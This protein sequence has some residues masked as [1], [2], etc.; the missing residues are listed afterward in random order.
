M[1]GGRGGPVCRT[2]GDLLAAPDS[3]I[4]DATSSRTVL[5]RMRPVRSLNSRN[6]WQA[7]KSGMGG[8]KHSYGAS[9]DFLVRAHPSSPK[10]TAR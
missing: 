10:T 1:N 2:V 5:D 3:H 7:G 6:Y 8:C 9:L 4:V